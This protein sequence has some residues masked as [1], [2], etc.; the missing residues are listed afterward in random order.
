MLDNYH[1][2]IDMEFIRMMWRFTE[3]I[4]YDRK[5]F[6]EERDQTICNFQNIRVAVGR[7]DKGDNGSLTSVQAL[8]DDC[9]ITQPE[10]RP[11]SRLTVPIPFVVLSLLQA[12]NLVRR[13]GECF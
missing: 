10:E 5:G 2:K 13:Q 4:T 11:V 3:S 9:S 12:G 1:G 8:P 7:P 6:E